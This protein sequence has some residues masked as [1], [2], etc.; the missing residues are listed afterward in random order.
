VT[1][2]L[3]T[4][5]QAVYQMQAQEEELIDCHHQLTE[6]STSLAFFS[7]LSVTLRIS[8]LNPSVFFFFSY[9]CR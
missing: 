8:L 2:E 1:D 3:L 4:F 5:H 6:V 9:A 7:F